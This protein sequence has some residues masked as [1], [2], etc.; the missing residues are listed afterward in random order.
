LTGGANLAT[1]P[2]RP[3]PARRLLALFCPSP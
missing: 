3:L 2:T 1:V